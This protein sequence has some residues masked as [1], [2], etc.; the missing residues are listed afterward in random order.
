MV[1]LMVKA[2]AA[3]IDRNTK[4]PKQIV[5]FMST[6]PGDQVALYKEFYVDRLYQRLNEL[7]PGNEIKLTLIM[8]N[9][10]TS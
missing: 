8:V 2:V 7:Y 4:S 3:Y 10:K 9:V 6:C 1:G 5:V